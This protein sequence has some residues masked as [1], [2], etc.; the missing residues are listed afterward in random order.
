MCISSCYFSMMRYGDAC[1]RSIGDENIN[2]LLIPHIAPV[3][4]CMPSAVFSF[5]RD[6]S[7]NF[8]QDF[9]D[10]S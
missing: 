10:T 1:R 4:N 6:D 2:L 3:C 5:D 8:L 7:N 9:R